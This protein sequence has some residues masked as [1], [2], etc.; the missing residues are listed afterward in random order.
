MKVKIFTEGGKD[1]GLGHIS[2]CSSLYDEIS[3]R[4]I[5]VDFIVFGDV[6]D[7]S[8]LTGI[9]VK[10]ENW[11]DKEYLIKDISKEDYVIVDSYRAD[12]EIYEIIA[13]NSK[14]ALYIDDIGRLDYPGGIIVNPALDSNHISYSSSS[15]NILLTGPKYVILR[16]SFIGLDRKFIKNDVSSVLIMMGGTDIRNITSLIIDKICKE[17]KSISFNVVFGNSKFELSKNI[18]L[19]N[20]SYHANLTEEEMSRIIH[21]A[22]L[23]IT[24]AGQTIYELIATQTPFIAV[25]IID[26]QKNNI[27]SIKKHISPEVLLRYDDDYFIENLQK[28]FEDIKDIEFRKSIVGKMNRIIDGLGRK[29]IVSALLEDLNMVDQIMLRKVKQEDIEQ[30]F[31]LSNQDYVRRYSINKN[32]IQWTDHNN[33]FKNILYDKN[34]VFYVVTD[35]NESFLGQIRF[36]IFNQS[37]TVSISLSEKL[38]GKGLS[39]TILCQSIDKL[40]EEKILVDEI[41][42]FVS[43]KNIASKKIFKGLNFK[44]AGIEEGLIKLILKRGMYYAN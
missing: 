28:T 21:K 38:R 43:E 23:A 41:I 5:A 40:F 9:Q 15:E 10:N 13:L 29:R 39:K 17:N 6:S 37:A 11:L 32:M 24:A 7:V 42:A 18:N 26:N 25:Q 27:A 22:D 4:G 33:W 14:K 1:I 20:V 35:E 34:V 36:N 2:R 19:K 30:V 44:K 16:S 12:M 3:S 8:F 31:E